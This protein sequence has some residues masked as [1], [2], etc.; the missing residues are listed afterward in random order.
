MR[1]SR[2]IDLVPERH[3]IGAVGGI[4]HMRLADLD[5]E[6]ILGGRCAACDY[7]NWVNRWEIARR[8]GSERT[9]DE[10]RQMLRC[11]RCGNKGNNGWRL[12]RIDRDSEWVDVQSVPHRS[13]V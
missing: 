13:S 6:Q 12:G 10:L 7:K 11:G 3:S 1:H 5:E 9:L 8:F 4:G 2:S